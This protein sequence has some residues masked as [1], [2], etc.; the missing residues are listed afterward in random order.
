MPTYEYVC[1]DCGA[2]IEVEAT[3]AEKEKGL[4]VTCPDCG[5]KK[6][7]QVFGG[8]S[9]MGSPR[10]SRRPPMCGPEAGPGCCR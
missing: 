5:S 1:T 9:V 4:K 6:V 8:F 3:I 7:A 2:G 10:G